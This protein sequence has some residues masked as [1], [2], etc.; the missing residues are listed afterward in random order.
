MTNDV[1]KQIWPEWQIE[2]QPLGK[3]SYGVVYKAVRR[4]HNVESYAAIKV[5]SIVAESSEI[6]S[7]RS[8][9][10]DMNATRTYLEGIVNDFVSEIQ[11]MESLKGVQNIVSVEDYK[12]IEKTDG[13]GWDIYIRMELL[14]PFNAYICDRKLSE[15]EVIRLGCDICTALE[16]CSQRNVIHRDIKPE[17]IFVN[18]FGHFKLGDFGIARKMENLTGGMSQK[19]TLNYMAPEVA[20]SRDYDARVD[21]Y[22]LGIVLY[23]LLNGNRL[24]FLNSEKQLLNP[25]DRRIA[26]EKRIRGEK[27]PDPC[28]AS[29][30]MA[31][32]IQRACAYNPDARFS[33]ATEMKEAL[34]SVKNGTYVF[35]PVSDPNATMLVTPTPVNSAPEI[36]NNTTALNETMGTVG[37]QNVN[38]FGN[39]PKKKSKLP[40]IIVAVLLALLLIGGGAFAAIKLLGDGPSN[41]VVSNDDDEDD[42]DNDDD[43]S[44]QTDKAS[45]KDKEKISSIISEAEE[46]AAKKN[47]A[48]ALTAIQEGLALYP[49]STQLQ[50]KEAEYAKLIEEEAI[51]SIIEQAEDIAANKDYEGAL[52]IIKDGLDIYPQ[53]SSLNDKKTEYTNE[54]NNQ[55]IAFVLA[56]AEKYAEIEDYEAAMSIIKEAQDV[57]GNNVQYQ[58]AYNTYN[59]KYTLQVKTEALASADIFA[60]GGDYENAVKVLEEALAKIKNDTELTNKIKEYQAADKGETDKDEDVPSGTIRDGEELEIKGGSSRAD[61]KEIKLEDIH[62]ASFTTAGNVDWFKVTSSA[63]YSLYRFKI[64]NLS[65]DG[66][67][68]IYITVYD[69]T[70]KQLGESRCTKGNNCYVDLQL[71]PGKT[72]YI[73]IHRDDKAK[74]GNYKLTVNENI[75]DAGVNKNE[76]FNILL[77][78]EYIKKFDVSQYADWYKVTVSDQYSLYRFK[79]DNL[80]IDG[81]YGIYIT[82]FDEYDAQLGESRCTKGNNCYVDL[83]LTPGETYYIRIS[84]DDGAKLGNYKLIV[85][86]YLCDAGVTKEEAFEIPVATEQMKKFDVSKFNEWYKVT[87]NSDNA[88][89]RFS[90]DNLSID[91]YYGIYIT[92]FDEYDAQLGESRCTKGKNCYVDLQLTS[93]ETYYIRISRDDGSKLGNYKLMVENRA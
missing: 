58:A 77:E 5:I 46:Y 12:V 11:L 87:I 72:Y 29:A 45:S 86:E 9:G 88:A 33:S 22:S 35:V 70:E 4:D 39:A 93:G 41:D 42:N 43:N 14:T 59:Q 13:I 10:L 91:G 3:G 74:L 68:G 53:S 21:T 54:L 30:A 60:Q 47:Y 18:D 16:I 85:N 20:N 31:N 64:D 73:R 44:S 81:Y 82:I 61:A 89:Y 40:L 67:Y 36:S 55:V 19:G 17:N 75:C 78:K 57:Y 37:N 24:P 6:D 56:D 23:R 50:K 25:N 65:I 90:L 66:Y 34:M 52:E 71:T 15:E 49:K 28:E 51:R 32:L 26:V 83:Q 79:I 2:G 76:S 80:S 48:E 38:T 7:L 8:E 63:N 84:R 92:I 1:L 62:H 27:M 69:E